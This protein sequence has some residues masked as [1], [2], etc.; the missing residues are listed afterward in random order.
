M[1]LRNRATAQL[2]VIAVLV[3]G[4]LTMGAGQA[5]ADPHFTFEQAARDSNGSFNV[6]VYANHV[7]AGKAEWNADP[8]SGAPGD[9]LR[10][11]DHY[12]EGWS[13]E[14][15]LYRPHRVATT[16]G[17][18]SPHWTGWKSGNIKEGTKVEVRI[19]MTRGYNSYCS[20]YYAGKA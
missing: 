20:D 6:A 11:Y 18:A 10:A 2:A 13:V 5:S 1:K 12:A 17:H 4:S 9:S 7:Y 3:G 19:C 8:V 16:A 14:A 15:I